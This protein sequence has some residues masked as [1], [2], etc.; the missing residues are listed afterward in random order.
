MTPL[1]ALTLIAI[2]VLATMI[3]VVTAV[4]NSSLQ[5][6]YRRVAAGFH[7]HVEQN[8]HLGWPT[9]TLSH[10]N[11]TATI[12]VTRLFGQWGV[13]STQIEIQER[14]LVVEPA[15][16]S[17]PFKLCS[18]TPPPRH[19]ALTFTCEIVPASLWQRLGFLVGS[20][21][22]ISDS[23]NFDLL[24]S[25]STDSR[26]HTRRLLTRYVQVQI[27]RIRYF[28]GGNDVHIRFRHGV[29]TVNR[30]GVIR[31][32]RAL[33]QFLALALELYEQAIASYGVGIDVLH[34]SS[35]PA[36]DAV[37]KV[38]GDPFDGEEEEIVFCRVCDTPHHRDCWRY[39]GGC[40]VYACGER[41]FSRTPRLAKEKA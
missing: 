18:S 4:R 8:G 17:S 33:R 31:N 28:Q 23:P 22:P 29:L 35:E 41:R 6:T 38:C 27:D 32:E 2:A 26:E 11:V 40:S 1:L 9:A 13:R 21:R 12:G 19:P 36:A 34:A 14:G 24:Y 10:R 5:S 37:C 7:G 15:D 39:F 30:R 20:R 16:E 25:I 3:V